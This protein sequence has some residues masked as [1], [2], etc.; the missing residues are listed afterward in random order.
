ASGSLGRQ[1]VINGGVYANAVNLPR[2]LGGS[3]CPSGPQCDNTVTPA[4]QFVFDAKYL[5]GLN[6][7]I[8]TPSIS[9]TETAP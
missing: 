7:I 1:L 5:A 3:L 6:N 2:K 9:W 8:G 4:N